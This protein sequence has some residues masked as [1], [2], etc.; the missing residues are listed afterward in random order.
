[1]L[2]S[3]SV[4]RDLTSK[5]FGALSTVKAGRR[6]ALRAV[7]R[8]LRRRHHRAGVRY[9]RVAWDDANDGEAHAPWADALNPAKRKTDDDFAAPRAARGDAEIWRKRDGRRPAV[10]GRRLLREH[11]FCNNYRELDRGTIYPPLRASASTSFFAGKRL[12]LKN[13]EHCLCEFEKYRNNGAGMRR[14]AS[15]AHL[16]AD[17]VCAVCEDATDAKDATRSLRPCN[18]PSTLCLDPP[19]HRVPETAGGS[20]RPAPAAGR[21]R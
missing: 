9:N 5:R 2:F 4:S 19:L 12:T 10:D 15:R 8:G 21:R 14:Y 11:A 6:R 18:A 17:V 7:L 3:L 20:A 13:A 1:M 16:D